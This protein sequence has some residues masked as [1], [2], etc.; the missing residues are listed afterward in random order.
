[1]NTL[2]LNP[3]GVLYV[4]MPGEGSFTTSVRLTHEELVTLLKAKHTARRSSRRSKTPGAHI[5][6]VVALAVNAIN[7]G[8]W[9]TGAEIDKTEILT[10]LVN[11]LEAL[12]VSEYGNITEK[13]ADSLNRLMYTNATDFPAELIAR[14]DDVVG[15]IYNERG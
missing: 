9:S 8:T 1:M 13:A 15:S 4:N 10:K 3:G 6:R 12:P 11:Q 14:L 2:E 7:K 5:S